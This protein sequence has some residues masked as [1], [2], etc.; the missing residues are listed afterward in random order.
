LAIKRYLKG[1]KLFL[2]K[3]GNSTINIMN[4]NEAPIVIKEHHQG[5]SAI[6]QMEHARE[7]S[8][9]LK[10]IRSVHTVPDYYAVAEI[11]SELRKGKMGQVRDVSVMQWIGARKV[12]DI[13]EELLEHPEDKRSMV[14]HHK[15]MTDYKNFKAALKKEGLPLTDFHE[16]N[17]LAK[18]DPTRRKYLFTII[19]Q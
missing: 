10:K 1:K 11:P 9:H 18:W 5:I 17:I 13:R 12:Q 7:I 6:G 4:A 19:D 14:T 3:S 15:L 2:L 8:S 16:G